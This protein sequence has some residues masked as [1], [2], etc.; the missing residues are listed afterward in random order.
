MRKLLPWILGAALA[1]PVAAARGHAGDG[2]RPGGCPGVSPSPAPSAEPLLMPE[3]NR[4][5]LFERSGAAST[6]ATWTRPST[7]RTGT[8][9]ATT[10]APLFLQVEDAWEIY[11]LTTEMV[12]EL[13]DDEVRFISPLVIENLPPGGG[14]LRGHRRARGHLRG[15]GDR[16]RA[17]HPVRVHG[18]SG[19]EEAGLAIRGPDRE[20]R[21]RSLR[22]H[23]QDPRAGGHHRH[24]GHQVARPGRAR[25]RRGAPAHRP[26]RLAHQHDGWARTARSAT[27]GCPRWRARTRSTA[28]PRSW[29]EFRDARRSTGLIIDVRSVR[30]GRPGR[31]RGHPRRTCS[32]ATPG[33]F[34]SRQETTPLELPDSD[35]LSAF[36]DLPHRGAHRR[37]ELRR[38]RAAGRDP[39]VDRPRDRRG[40]AH[41][42]R[43]RASSRTSRSGDGSVLSLVTIGLEL[44]DG[45]KLERQGIT[46]DVP[47]T[48]DWLDVPEAD[49]P[50]ILAALDALGAAAVPSVAPSARAR[51]AVGRAQP[52]ARSRR[53]RRCPLAERRADRRHPPPV[54][55]PPPSRPP[56]PPGSPARRR[57]VREACPRRS[58]LLLGVL[59]AATLSIVP[60][61]VAEAARPS[62]SRG[63]RVAAGHRAP[64]ARRPAPDGRPHLGAAAHHQAPVPR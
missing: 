49:D 18:Q 47:I 59:L 42:G 48:E 55:R 33:T 23:P 8:P 53:H 39:P 26:D 37:G 21:R 27:C 3:D 20:R 25:G 17:A 38:A 57:H 14:R 12:D 40:A 29:S 41:G 1:I 58:P 6:P 4:L 43:A 60:P 30:P 28:S 62:A 44:P 2:P 63:R 10:Y 22:D 34:Y 19:A 15:G 35:L 36:K 54:R 52:V 11:D 7:A 5:A 31:D 45:T 16:R 9:S 56:R 46:P 64:G 32:T 50:Y 13:G 61:D 51:G 24:A